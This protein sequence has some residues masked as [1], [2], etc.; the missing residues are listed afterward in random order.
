VSE[1]PSDLPIYSLLDVYSKVLDGRLTLQIGVDV[2]A[3]G[4]TDA[5]L[6][7][8]DIAVQLRR[9]AHEVS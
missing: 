5:A 6:I 9:L 1:T 3:V 8:D 2:S 4:P 7:V